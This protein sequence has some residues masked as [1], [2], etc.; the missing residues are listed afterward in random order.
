MGRGMLTRSHACRTADDGAGRRVASAGDGG[1]GDL[2]QPERPVMT[3]RSP[4]GAVGDD[5]L[6]AAP[7]VTGVHAHQN[8]LDLVLASGPRGV[9]GFSGPSFTCRPRP[10]L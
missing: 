7:L 5:L 2:L 1:L 10:R 4:T 6:L 8:P 9:A 3:P